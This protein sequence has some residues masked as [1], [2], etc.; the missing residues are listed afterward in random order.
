MEYLKPELVLVGSAS[1]VVLG[2]GALSV[3]GSGHDFEE[4]PAASLALG[5]DD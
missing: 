2:L 3:D 1:T 4:I 5:L